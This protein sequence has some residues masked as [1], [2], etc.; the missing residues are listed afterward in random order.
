MQAVKRRGPKPKSPT[1]QPMK[2]RVIRMDDADWAATK[3]IGTDM[4]RELIRE[5]AKKKGIV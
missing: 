4:A 5:D 3:A 1:G 2:R